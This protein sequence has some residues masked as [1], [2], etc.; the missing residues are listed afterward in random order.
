MAS[1]GSKGSFLL[2]PSWIIGEQCNVG[3]GGAKAI[4]LE[5]QQAVPGHGSRLY[6]LEKGSSEE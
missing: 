2:F 5:N 4:A 1:A 6:D 3:G